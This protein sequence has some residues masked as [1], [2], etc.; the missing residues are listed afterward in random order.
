MTIALSVCLIIYFATVL[1]AV[2]LAKVSAKSDRDTSRLYQELMADRLECSLVAK[3][4]KKIWID[5]G[6][7]SEE[8]SKFY[9]EVEELILNEDKE[10]D[11]TRPTRLYESVLL[12]HQDQ[13]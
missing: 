8:W 2:G 3:K 6:A 5:S 7:S 4:T 10:A 1:M 12:E 9:K 13:S 11:Q